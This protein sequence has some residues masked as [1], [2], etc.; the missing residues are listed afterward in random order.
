MLTGLQTALVA[1]AVRAAVAVEP[2]EVRGAEAFFLWTQIVIKR[3]LVAS[4]DRV[5]CL[6][7]VPGDHEREKKGRRRREEEEHYGRK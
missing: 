6:L 1:V 2:F 4:R 5:L 3:T 7:R